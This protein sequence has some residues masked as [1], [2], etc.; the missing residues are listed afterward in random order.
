M[1]ELGI[2]FSD[3]PLIF[4]SSFFLLKSLIGSL[5]ITKLD[6]CFKKFEQVHH[7]TIMDH[8]FDN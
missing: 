7:L 3:E 8:N 4:D 1:L 5:K 2:Y 6:I